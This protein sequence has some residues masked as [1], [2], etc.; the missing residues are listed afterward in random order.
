MNLYMYYVLVCRNIWESKSKTSVVASGCELL[1]WK[2]I[3]I[4]KIIIQ[5]EVLCLKRQVSFAKGN[6]LFPDLNNSSMF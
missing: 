1:V 4:I 3:L 5:K 6:Y 2:G